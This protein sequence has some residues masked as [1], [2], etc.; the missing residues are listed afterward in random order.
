VRLL[1]P[2]EPR[3]DTGNTRVRLDAAGRIVAVHDPLRAPAGNVLLDWVFPLHS[4]EAFGLVARVLWS[5]FGTVP[6]LLLG[7]GLYLWWRRTRKRV[8]TTARGVPP[9]LPLP[10]QPAT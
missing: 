10:Q 3:A 4:G 1:Q 2:G 6:A 8:D 9:T 5:A 7:S